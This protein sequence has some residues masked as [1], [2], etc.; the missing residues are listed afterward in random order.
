MKDNYETTIKDYKERAIRWKEKSLAQLSFVNNLIL[1]LSVVFLTFF[2]REFKTNETFISVP[3]NE[4]YILLMKISLILILLSIIT[5]VL[6]AINRLIDFRITKEIARIRYKAYK[7]TKTKLVKKNISEIKFPNKDFL[8]FKI[9]IGKLHNS[10]SINISNSD[11]NIIYNKLR[12]TTFN[13]GKNTWNK[14][15]WQLLFFV[16]AISIYIIGL[17]INK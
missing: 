2:Y 12:E 5:G 10:D 17:L 8:L 9:L 7:E 3:I 4:K 15:L 1:S 13:L 14:T 16:I 11:I 6:V